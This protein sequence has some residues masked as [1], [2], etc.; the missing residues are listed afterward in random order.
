MKWKQ[1]QPKKK[2]DGD[3]VVGTFFFFKIS[4]VFTISCHTNLICIIIIIRECV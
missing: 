4:N 1:K 3:H 2:K